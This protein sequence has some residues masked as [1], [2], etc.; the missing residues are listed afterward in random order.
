VGSAGPGWRWCTSR[1]SGW[2]IVDRSPFTRFSHPFSFSSAGD[3]A[4]SGRIALTIRALGNVSA[5]VA[6]L[7]VGAKV[8]VDG[9]HG[10]FT[11][12]RQQAQ[13][14]VFIG[15][16]VGITTLFTLD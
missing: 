6:T 3:R 10:V 11:M 7:P 5:Q 2:I 1:G 8:Y 12:D 4:D 14:Y 15:G 9:P 13:G 16:G